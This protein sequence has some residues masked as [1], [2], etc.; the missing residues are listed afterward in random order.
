MG[1]EPEIA[2]IRF[3]ALMRWWAEDNVPSLGTREGP[4]GSIDLELPVGNP[5]ALISWILG[6]GGQARIISPDSLKLRLLD[7][8]SP[9][10]Q[11]QGAGRRTE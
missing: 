7:H 4:D 6:L 3:D 5:D 1:D 2:V 9:F 11:E 10:T 8:L